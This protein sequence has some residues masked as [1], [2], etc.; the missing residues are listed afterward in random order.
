[1]LARLGQP[2]PFVDQ[3]TLAVLF[4]GLAGFAEVLDAGA[5]R[6]FDSRCRR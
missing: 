1:M 5:H 2:E 4:R 6:V 3:A